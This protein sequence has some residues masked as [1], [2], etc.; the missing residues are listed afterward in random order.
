MTS[1]P[2]STYKA[3]VLEEHTSGNFTLENV[4]KPELVH[5]SA[6]IR[7][8]AAGILPYHRTVN[9]HYPFLSPL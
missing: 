7:I 6:L 2:L 5:G 8:S 4:S 3:L 1:T 9:Q